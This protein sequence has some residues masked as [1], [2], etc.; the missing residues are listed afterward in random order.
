MLTDLKTLEDKL[1]MPDIL[2]WFHQ[3]F[4]YIIVEV[5]CA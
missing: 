2:D 1:Y 5:P 3:V 4:M